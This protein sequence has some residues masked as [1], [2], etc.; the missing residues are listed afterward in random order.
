MFF[1]KYA[2]VNLRRF[3]S[4]INEFIEIEQYF[5][6][7]FKKVVLFIGFVNWM[8]ALSRDLTS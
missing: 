1:Q 3:Y 6:M 5:D 8:T 2:A 7:T 4:E